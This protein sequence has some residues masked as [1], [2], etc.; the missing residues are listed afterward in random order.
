MDLGRRFVAP[1]FKG[2]AGMKQFQVGGKYQ[3]HGNKGVVQVVKRS[4][5]YV[6]LAGTYSGRLLVRG[7]LFG[8]F[9]FLWVP[10]VV[11]AGGYKLPVLCFA[12]NTV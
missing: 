5:H 9:E 4:A 2:G 12:D 7:G 11:G 6:A 1:I 3:L 10:V 8:D